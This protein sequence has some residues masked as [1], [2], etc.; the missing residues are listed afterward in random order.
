MQDPIRIAITGGA[1]QIGYQIL[2]RI[3]A[4]ELLGKHVPIILH[5]LERADSLSSLQ[6][7][8]MELQDSAYPLLK[9]VHT[10]NDPYKIFDGIDLAFLIGAKPRSPGMERS[11]LLQENAKIFMEQGKALSAQKKAKVLVI[12]NPCNTNALVLSHYAKDLPKENIRAM[13]K[14]D[15][16]RARSKLALK[17]KVSLTD[18]TQLAIWGNHSPTMFADYA[19]ALV[20]GNPLETVI[21]DTNWLENE[22]LQQVQHRGAEILRVRGVSSAASAASS[23]IDCMRDWLKEERSIDWYSA[24]VY[25]QNNPYEIE[26]ELYFSFPLLHGQIIPDIEHSDFAEKAISASEEELIRERDLVRQML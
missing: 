2:F 8:V 10:G 22:F 9:E 11:D 4:G 20:Q 14:L 15:E 6:G 19:N 12:G 1:G 26:E 5:I 13:T 3:A 25:T 23:A 16:N 18:V 21:Q 17:A 24:A 7:V